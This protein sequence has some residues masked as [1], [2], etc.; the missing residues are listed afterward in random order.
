MHTVQNSNGTIEYMVKVNP[1]LSTS[2]LHLANS[3]PL[4]R[5]LLSVSHYHFIDMVS[6]HNVLCTYFLKKEEIFY[7]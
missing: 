1:P 7:F 4:Q 3:L 2:V 6:V 5:P